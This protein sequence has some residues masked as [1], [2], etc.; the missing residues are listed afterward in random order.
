MLYSLLKPILF[1]VDAELAHE[2]SLDLLNEFSTLLPKTRIENPTR[3]MGIDFPNPV[4]LAAG[5]DKDGDYLAGLSTLG[6]GFIELGTVTPVAQ[7]GNPKPRLFRLIRHRSIINRMGF[8]NKGVDYLLQRVPDRPRPYVL[9]I[10]IGKN[11][12]TP[13][14][15]A[16]SDYNICLRKVYPQADYISVNISSPNTPRLR[17]LQNES[18]LGELLYG[19]NETRKSLQDQYQYHRPIALKIAPDLDDKAIPGIAELLKKHQI[20]A[21]IAT[22]TTLDRTLVGGHPLAA[23]YGGLSGEG[24]CHKSRHVLSQFYQVLQ[25]EIP[26]ISVGGILSADEA[27]LRMQLGAS[28]VQLYTGLIYKGPELVRESA[29]VRL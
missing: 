11:L 4:G 9:G 25:G 28:L 13:V 23:E 7:A 8:N 19:I 18:A 15:N 22:N 29:R 12:A 27:L 26:I 24:L 6:F 16:L 10:N 2:I 17:S 5:L 3:V 1:S 20:D 14:E 21:L